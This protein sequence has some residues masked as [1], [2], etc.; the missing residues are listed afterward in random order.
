MVLNAKIVRADIRCLNGV[1]HE[2]DT[3]LTPPESALPPLLPPTATTN[4]PPA[5]TNAPPT[6]T[7]APAPGADTN[8]APV[9]PSPAPEPPAQ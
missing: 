3:V 6:A 1:I 9:A 8:A 4:A 7:P 2:I 5:T